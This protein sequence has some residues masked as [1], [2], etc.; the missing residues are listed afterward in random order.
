MSDAGHAVLLSSLM[1]VGVVCQVPPGALRAGVAR[2]GMILPPRQ[3]QHG[4]GSQTEQAPPPPG[5][6]GRLP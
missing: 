5:I 6:H 4:R 1:V 3:S 2:P